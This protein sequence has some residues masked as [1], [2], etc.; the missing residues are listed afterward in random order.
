MRAI[1][2]IVFGI[3][4]ALPLLGILRLDMQDKALKKNEINFRVASSIYQS[5]F[6]LDPASIQSLDQYNFLENLYGRLVEYNSKNQLVA[7]VA[8]SFY[9]TESSLVFKFQGKAKAV[10]GEAITAD[11]AATS[12]KR[13]I[14]LK[15]SSHA[16]LRKIL[17]PETD[18]VSMEDRCEGITVVGNELILTPIKKSFG[19]VLITILENADFSIIPARALSRDPKDPKIESLKITSGPYYL[20]QDSLEGGWRLSANKNH[21]KYSELM[22]QKITAVPTVL[23]EVN[24]KFEAGLIDLAPCSLPLDGELAKLVARRSDLYGYYESLPLKV[25][26]LYFSPSA[27]INFTS[28]Q[29]FF[30]ARVIVETL[31]KI[32]DLS[33]DL[34]TSEFLQALSDGSISKEQKAQIDLR[35]IADSR[36]RFFKKIRLMVRLQH[37]EKWKRLLANYPEIDVFGSDTL[38]IVLPVAQ[39]PDIYFGT[40]DAAWNESLS[41]IEYNFSSGIFH[42]PNFNPENWIEKYMNTPDRV[43]RI[44][45]L[46]ELHFNLLKEPIIYPITRGP[47]RAF[48]R[49]PWAIE[50][51]RFSA[52]GEFWR[53]RKTQ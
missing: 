45:M 42:L 8:D 30:A 51:S 9:W 31:N 48:S 34:P 20:E 14:F 10:D 32:I 40:N 6:S 18:L 22:P 21:Y 7:G 43:E 16:D 46:S 39:R 11:D 49:S 13:L 52:G 12:L 36:P 53:V 19:P 38:P 23:A 4:I 5:A 33:G 3:V 50:F 17:C 41:L 15:R 28:E 25:L 44:G 24:E 47:Y 27:A 26:M 1:R 2:L 29:R 35:R 37:L